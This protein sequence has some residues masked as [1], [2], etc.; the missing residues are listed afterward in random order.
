MSTHPMWMDEI[1]RCIADQLS[2]S[3]IRG[4]FGLSGPGF[5]ELKQVYSQHKHW[6]GPLVIIMT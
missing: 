5:V 4:D 2:P 3:M 1:P 6:F